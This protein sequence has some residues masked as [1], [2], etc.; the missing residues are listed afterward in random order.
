MPD[1]A[2][3][4]IGNTQYSL[5]D[6]VAREWIA[7][8]VD[9]F[10]PVGSIIIN[11]GV[12]PG[13]Y[14]LGTT[15][16]QTSVGR[17][18]VG[19]DNSNSLMDNAEESFGSANAIIPSH[20]H[21]ASSSNVTLSTNS[22]GS[23]LHG[24]QNVWS[25]GTTG[26]YEAYLMTNKRSRTTRYTDYSGDHTHSINAHSHAITVNPT[27]EDVTNKNYQPSMAF[28]IWKRIA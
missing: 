23:H 26:S 14:L 22:A 2:Y 12:D 6:L 28:Y 18:I 27:G 7:N 24:M 17:A 19:V 15:W 20:S 25:A 5:K 8:A 16:E 3:Y 13:S 10:Y 1:I 4:T 9:L 21:T 11:L